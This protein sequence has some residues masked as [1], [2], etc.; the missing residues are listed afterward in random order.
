MLTLC[1]LICGCPYESNVPIDKPGVKINPKLIGSWEAQEGQQEG[2]DVYNVSRKDDFTY[3]IEV[4]QKQDNKV[5]HSTG[6]SSIVN[7]SIFLNIADDKPGSEKKYSLYKI[8]MHGDN[9]LKVYGVT[10]N[11]RENFASSGELK[12]FIAANMKNSYFFEKPV[13]FIRI[14]KTKWYRCAAS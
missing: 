12:K 11:V 3:A 2:Q 8:E 7:G 13:N 4:I 9:A 14:E 1:T 6:Y 10:E 5:D